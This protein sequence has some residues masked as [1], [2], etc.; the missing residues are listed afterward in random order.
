MVVLEDLATQFKLKTQAAI[1]RITDLHEAG[2]L[3]SVTDG[4]GK[5]IYISDKELLV[6][7]SS[8]AA[9]RSLNEFLVSLCPYMLLSALSLIILLKKKSG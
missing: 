8:K 3:S 9:Y 5:F 1:D 2:T 6:S 7:F 4:Q